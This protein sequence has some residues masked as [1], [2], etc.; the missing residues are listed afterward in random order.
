MSNAPVS[1]TK[2]LT[3]ES[4]LRRKI[5]TRGL[6]YVSSLTRKTADG[7]GAEQPSRQLMGPEPERRGKFLSPPA[8]PIPPTPGSAQPGV[9]GPLGA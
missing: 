1:G 2:R 9:A 5:K 7:Q 8:Q 3:A 4:T 6:A